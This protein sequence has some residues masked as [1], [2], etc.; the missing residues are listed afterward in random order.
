MNQR[1]ARL[2]WTAP[3]V[4]LLVLGWVKSSSGGQAQGGAAKDIAG[5]FVSFQDGALTV[6]VAHGKLSGPHTF[7]V[8]AGIPVLVYTSPGHPQMN[9][10]PGGLQ[11]IA[12]DTRVEVTVDSRDFVVRISV[13]EKNAKKKP[14]SN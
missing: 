14:S 12:P 7:Q 8:P 13:G 9:H 1:L 11:N 10:S 4:V 2:A 3:L 6:D 5:K